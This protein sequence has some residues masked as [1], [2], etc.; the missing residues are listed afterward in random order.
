[1]TTPL[2]T[3]TPAMAGLSPVHFHSQGMRWEQMRQAI[4]M[5]MGHHEKAQH[6]AERVE[7]HARE[8]FFAGS[9]S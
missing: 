9:D 2:R 1:M 5:Q 7:H 6:C 3:I 8:L 4:F